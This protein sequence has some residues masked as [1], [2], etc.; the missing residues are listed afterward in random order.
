MNK[1][2]GIIGGM[3]P[4]ATVKFFENIVLLTRANRDQDHIH[5]LIDNNTSIP[6]RTDYILGIDKENPK[7]ELIKSAKNLQLMGANYLVMPC[8][9]AHKFY[10]EIVKEVNIPFLNM[11][12]ETA[13]SIKRQ[14]PH[15]KKIGLLSTEGTIKSKIYDH[16]FERYN[17]KITNLSREKQKYITELIYNIKKGIHQKNINKVYEAIEELKEKD[18]EIIIAGCTEVSVAMD[19]YNIDENIIDPM[20]ILSIRAIEFADRKV[21]EI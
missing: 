12:E 4:L 14:N 18:V 17:M 19:I 1:I 11:I 13:K 2:L 8:N 7:N 16:I 15:I 21:K 6:D 3:G 5:I 20:E 10:D 9:T